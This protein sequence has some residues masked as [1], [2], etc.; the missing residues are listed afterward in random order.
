MD[1]DN[2]IQ[3]LCTKVGALWLGVQAEEIIEIVKPSSEGFHHFEGEGRID[4]IKYN[5]EYIPLIYL[6]ELLTGEKDNY[7]TACK[8]LITEKDQKIL[9]M[10]VGSA[11]EILRIPQG[12]LNIT[13]TTDS[14]I[15][16][17]TIDSILRVEDRK[18]HIISV[19]KVFDLIKIES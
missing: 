19:S 1:K 13:T 14:G 8:V 16:S 10:V 11:E 7:I 15:K 3:Y 12:E 9:G 4:S 2:I 17:E 18:I 5:D 6:R